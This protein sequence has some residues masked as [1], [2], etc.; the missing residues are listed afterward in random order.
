MFST[1]SV[2]WM[3]L[4]GFIVVGACS[5]D[6]SVGSSPG[7]GAA[8][9][10]GAAAN[11]AGA[12]S[13][14]AAS[15][16]G[17]AANGAGVATGAAASGSGVAADGAGAATGT[18][19]SAGQAASSGTL[20]GGQGAGPGEDWDVN[21]A[22][23]ACTDIS[24][25]TTGSPAIL[26]FVID[27]STSMNQSAPS[28]EPGSKWDATVEALVGAF[29]NIDPSLAVGEVFYPNVSVAGRNPQGCMD[30]SGGVDI[31]P[32]SDPAQVAALQAGVQAVPNPTTPPGTPT[33]DAWREG[34]R[35]VQEALADPPPGFE[36]ARG[37]IVLVTDGM[38]TH[39]I[40]CGPAYGMGDPG[41]RIAVDAAQWQE[42]IDDV[43]DT[44]AAT[45]IQTFVVGVPGSENDNQVPMINGQLDYVPRGKLSELAVAGGT[46]IDGCSN[47]G[48]PYCHLDM[49]DEPDFVAGL[50]TVIG[51][52]VR[53]IVSC[54]Y[55]VPDVPIDNVFV[56]PDDV[57]VYYFAAGDTSNPIPLS[58][59]T[60]D[61][62]SGEWT[63]NADKTVITLC[64]SAC[65]TVR[66]DPVAAMEV[67]FGCVQPL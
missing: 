33:H 13:G 22:T 47:D 56:N 66:A 21:Y 40:D 61:C 34:L 62:A 46:A 44:A 3:S 67:Y 7:G 60:D 41:G 4:L 10:S 8:S 12:A 2:T 27:K 53:S 29:P 15:G 52:I 6:G 36:N 50:Q 58:Q 26:E 14:T 1:K 35:R 65:T 19:T 9:G 43:G 54:E 59:S 49:V 24:V 23:D 20:D 31:G 39:T 57:V 38:P 51:D 5:S 17:A 45:G 48:N 32:M 30:S 37:Y 64:P 18:G 25:G 28:T 55:T 42:I 16:S 63:Y 11:G